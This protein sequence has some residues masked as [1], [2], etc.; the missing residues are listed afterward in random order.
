MTAD[1]L[2]IVPVTADRF[3]DLERLFGPKG[4]VSGCWCQVF[5]QARQEWRTT[6]GAVRHEMLRAETD[7]GGPVGLIAYAGDEPVGWVRITPRATVPRFN[8]IPTGRPAG[9]IDGVWA[10]TCF[11]TARGWRGKGLMRT[12]AKAACRYAAENGASAVDAAPLDTT[13]KLVW[14][15]GFVGIASSL[16]A[17]G[18]VEIERRTTSRVLMRWTPTD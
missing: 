18:F 2:T 1:D 6:D 9:E 4:P 12:L 5:R 17:V 10:L 7:T 8:T 3:A 14:G 13:R 11:F 16:A 15:E